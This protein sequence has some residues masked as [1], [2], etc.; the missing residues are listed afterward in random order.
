M[1]LKGGLAGLLGAGILTLSGCEPPPKTEDTVPVQRYVAKLVSYTGPA[2]NSRIG[3]YLDLS[4]PSGQNRFFVLD[5]RRRKVLAAGLCCSGRTTALGKVVYSN[6][7]DSHCS[8]RG[9]AKVSYAYTG[10]FGRAYKLVGLHPS[11][12]NIFSR[13]IVLHAHSCV[14]ATPQA[15]P[16]CRSQ[17]C[18]TVNPQFLRTLD[19]YIRKSRR[20][21][22]LYTQ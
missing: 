4:R 7:P 15:L 22:L 20:P 6:T 5:L 2:Y 17:G 21:I 10:T 19:G 1:N 11:N 9:L 8:S 18:P 14:P 12:S 3:F 13:F 16:I